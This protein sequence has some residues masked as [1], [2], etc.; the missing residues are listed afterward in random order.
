MVGFAFSK[1][2]AAVPEFSRSP[3]VNAWTFPFRSTTPPKNPISSR[4]E[5]ASFNALSSAAENLSRV[6]CLRSHP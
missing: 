1:C 4:F 2:T 5:I 3:I 6:Q